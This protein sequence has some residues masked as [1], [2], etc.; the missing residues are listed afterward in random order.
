MKKN[1]LINN[2]K[3][4]FSLFLVLFTGLSIAENK[5][6]FSLSVL[7]DFSYSSE[8]SAFRSTG[9][10]W[11]AMGKFNEQT[12]VMAYLHSPIN[13]TP[14]V[15]EVFVDY[16][17][18]NQIKVGYF[19]PN[20]GWLNK[21]HFHTYNFISSPK[22]YR[23]LMGE[24]H[25]ASLGASAGI[26][27][28]LTWKSEISTQLFNNHFGEVEIQ[29]GHSHGIILSDSLRQGMVSGIS[30]THS[31]TSISHGTITLKAGTLSGRSKKLQGLAIQWKYKNDPYRSW[32]IQ[33]EYL[34]GDISDSHHGI[35]FHPDEE[36]NT[37]YI[38]L[39]RQFNKKLHLG[40]LADQWAYRLKSTSGYSAAI[41]FAYAPRGD[42]WVIRGK[43]INESDSSLIGVIQ[44][45]WALGPHK[46]QRY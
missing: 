25:W 41:F 17:S 31:F 26:S 24:N 34:K 16:K 20:I 4:K 18:S 7:S 45:N 43:I 28:P 10:E 23:L 35:S 22:G 2:L 9:L 40:V 38:L 8:D 13:G 15:E 21:A 37:A 11:V 44:L 27:L 46:P 19:R 29:D 3:F 30:T 5:Y 32:I 42:N 36:L 12:M 6:P 14:M 1:S 33:G 39:G